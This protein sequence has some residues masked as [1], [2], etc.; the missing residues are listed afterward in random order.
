MIPVLKQTLDPFLQLCT[1]PVIF[2]FLY[3]VEFSWLHMATCVSPCTAKSSF[4]IASSQLLKLHFHSKYTWVLFQ[5]YLTCRFNK[6]FSYLI[7]RLS[8]KIWYRTRLRTDLHSIFL[9]RSIHSDTESEIA[10]LLVQIFWFLATLHPLYNNLIC[11]LFPSF[12]SENTIWD[13]FK[14]LTQP[15]YFS[16]VC[17]PVTD[18]N[19]IL[20]TSA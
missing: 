6:P 14:N 3:E 9:N 12:A 11:V 15:S 10:A 20:S 19:Q 4:F 16:E 17:Y 5:L 8:M 1:R 18:R 7:P 2:W 13:G